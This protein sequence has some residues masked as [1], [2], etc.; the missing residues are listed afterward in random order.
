MLCVKFCAAQSTVPLT[1]STK[2]NTVRALNGF[3]V[4]SFMYLPSNGKDSGN[5]RINSGVLQYH[6]N[7]GWQT[8]G[9]STNVAVGNGLKM[10]GDSI[11]LGSN[12]DNLESANIEDGTFIANY[13]VDSS[14]IRGL[15]FGFPDLSPFLNP[16]SL[17]SFSP[18]GTGE[19]MV[20]TGFQFNGGIL[21]LKA[22]NSSSGYNLTANSSGFSESHSIAAGAG[23]YRYMSPGIHTFQTISSGSN[24][25]TL[26]MESDSFSN[27][28]FSYENGKSNGIT[29]A[30]RFGSY[31][32]VILTD[33][34]LIY[35]NYADSL[36]N[37]LIDTNIVSSAATL[38]LIKKGYYSFNG[39]ESTWTLPALTGNI[40]KRY[41]ISNKGSGNITLNAPSNTLW[42][43]NVIGT[44]TVIAPGE[45]LIIYNDSLHWTVY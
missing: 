24:T 42:E 5:I 25:G 31:K 23:A 39:S 44:T 18:Y 8:I 22:N 45:T 11:S 19:V 29:Y 32:D 7:E 38:S 26:I 40:T 35:K 37:L 4:D 1:G 9:G 28:R 43:A 12:I 10:D 21:N 3:K 13:N 27:I 20:G 16:L 36:Y 6:N 17:R 34:T 15:L 30:H 33:S 14:S 41:I 2:I